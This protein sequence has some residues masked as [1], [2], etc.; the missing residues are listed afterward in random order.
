MR[1]IFALV[2]LLCLTGCTTFN[3]TVFAT[4]S[5][6]LKERFVASQY[7]APN[8]ITMMVRTHYPEI[9]G[10]RK[11]PLVVYL[12]GA[13]QN[14]TDNERQLDDGVGCLYSFAAA[15]NREDYKAV[16]LVPQCPAGV[17]WRD[18]EMLK[19]LKSL[20]ESYA[21][22]PLID[23][24]RVFITGFSMG[25][26]ASWK[27]GLSYPNLMSTIVPVC[28]G[29]LASMEPDIPD[30]PDEMAS[31]NVWAFNNFDDG[32]VRPAYSKRIFAKL[33]ERNDG[34][35]LNFTE[36]VSGG[37]NGKQVYSNRNVLIWMFSTKRAK[38]NSH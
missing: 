32:T 31:L 2:A 15:E 30:V 26:D 19:A 18:E 6:V 37:H 8:G 38:R 25:G 23:E 3:G 4:S 17:Y 21:D 9:S 11:F 7:E 27:L 14:G 13:G 24:D 12:H 16:I 28:G 35:N 10:M 1:N 36:F 34:D 33:W 20:I 29:P 22:N 5:D